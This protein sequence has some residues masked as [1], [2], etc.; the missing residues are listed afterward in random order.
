MRDQRN[1]SSR[2]CAVPAR[3]P[4]TRSAPARL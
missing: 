2:V 1:G 4:R 3:A